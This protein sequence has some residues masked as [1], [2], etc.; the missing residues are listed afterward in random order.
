MTANSPLERFRTLLRI[1]T[2][3]HSDESLTDWTQFDAFIE[4]V[5]DLY[6]KVHS[7]LEREM[8]AGHS[9]LF[10]WR[11]TESGSPSVLMAHY[12]VVPATEEG[13]VHPPFAAQLVSDGVEEALWGRGTLDDKGA[14]VS[15]LEAVED[16][17]LAGYTPRNDIYLSFGHNEE[18]AGG[19][20]V[21]V[22]ELLASRDIRPAF[23]CDEG[24]AIVEGVFPG[25]DAPIAVIGVAEKGI[26]T[27]ILSVD[28]AGGHASTPPPLTATTRLARAIVRLHKNPFPARFSQTNIDMIHTIGKHGKGVVGAL[29]RAVKITR[30][31]L[32][33]AFT[34]L[35]EETNA[36]VRTTMAVTQLSGSAAANVLAERATA[37]VNI[38]VAVGSSIDETVSHVRR[39]IRDDGVHIEVVDESE[40]SAVSPIS[41]NAWDALTASIE[42][43]F[44]GTVVTPYIQ[45]GASDSRR[46]NAISDHVYRFS[47]FEMSRD[48]RSTLHAMNENISVATWHRGI[49]FFTTLISRL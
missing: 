17:L 23:V 48:Q 34:R 45:L 14:L 46:F 40:P 38:R 49:Q 20:A 9:M 28:Q 3:S 16:L 44:P 5:A 4:T 35:S 13:W 42:E 21:A 22:V 29:F 2:I 6:P 26:M 39:A 36:I 11:G 30:P 25:V 43:T 7:E 33:L 12:D 24:G 31:L 27:L 10:R 1:P 41:G 8:V 47:P 32:L 37:S 18:T 15:I 19:G